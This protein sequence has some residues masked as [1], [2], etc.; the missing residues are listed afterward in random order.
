M[1]LIK[2]DVDYSVWCVVISGLIQIEEIQFI[3]FADILNDS[4]NMIIIV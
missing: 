1:K 3:D 2:I 4:R